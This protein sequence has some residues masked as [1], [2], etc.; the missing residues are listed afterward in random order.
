M[1]R[2]RTALFALIATIATPGL[3]ACSG[4]GN[5]GT[6][7]TG[8]AAVVGGQRISVATVENQVSSFRDAAPAQGSGSG[9]SRTF[10]QD[11]AGMP[12][13]VLGFLIQEQ[14]VQSALDQKGLSVSA[15]D[16]AAVE[17][18][19]LKS[20]G[21]QTQLTA[22]FVNQVGLPPEDL[23]SYFRWQA[24]V[25]ALLGSV[26]GDSAKLTGLLQP[27]AADLR[28]SVNPR[29]GSWDTTKLTLGDS[30]QPWIKPVSQ[31]NAG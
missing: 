12:A 21:S 10:G 14:V 20:A 15:T 13:N 3:S 9:S 19:F 28:I 23:E 24:G 18:P 2:T 25:K 26:G 22:E 5:A 6:V 16:V 1:N 17:A 29:Y 7:H 8:A 30:A 11:S 27:V 31:D 4:S